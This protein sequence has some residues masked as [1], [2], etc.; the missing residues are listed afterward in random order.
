V[1]VLAV[2]G[3]A[4]GGVGVLGVDPVLVVLPQALTTITSTSPMAMKNVCFDNNRISVLL[5]EEIVSRPIRLARELWDC[6]A[7]TLIIA[8][9]PQ[10]NLNFR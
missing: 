5:S 1:E 6:S 2:V 9:V 7:A 10:E 3:V 8:A 4:V